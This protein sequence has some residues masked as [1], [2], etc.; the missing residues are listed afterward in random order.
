M[1]NL[2]I[3]DRIREN[4]NWWSKS[5]NATA[6]AASSRIQASRELSASIF[7]QTGRNANRVFKYF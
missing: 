6:T 1:A 2:I 7:E 3:S 4:V 5:Q